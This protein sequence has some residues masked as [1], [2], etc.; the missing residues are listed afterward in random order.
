MLEGRSDNGAPLYNRERI[1]LEPSG[2]ELNFQ[3][4]YS[5]EIDERHD[6]SAGLML[7]LEPG[8]NADADAEGVGLV[9]YSVA[10]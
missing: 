8:H 10:F 9:R 4:F 7:R 1:S 3:S 2:R 6:F 5:R